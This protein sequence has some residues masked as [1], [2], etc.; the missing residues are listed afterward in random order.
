MNKWGKGDVCRFPKKDTETDS[1]VR[2]LN[3]SHFPHIKKN[4]QG[5]AEFH[6]YG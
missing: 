2:S 4:A 3:G 6:G 1:P 5:L